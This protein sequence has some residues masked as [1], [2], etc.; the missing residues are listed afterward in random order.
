MATKVQIDTG[1]PK[2]TFKGI[3]SNEVVNLIDLIPEITRECIYVLIT[4]EDGDVRC[5]IINN[6]SQN[7]KFGHLLEEGTILEIRNKDA[8]Y[9]SKFISANAQQS[10][11][12]FITVCCYGGFEVE[13]K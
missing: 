5:S 3:V 6:P 2:G 4:I 8:I 7:P 13:E 12:L 11:T 9:N 1:T 10:V